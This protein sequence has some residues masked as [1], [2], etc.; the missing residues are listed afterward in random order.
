MAKLINGGDDCDDMNLNDMNHDYAMQ[1][2]RLEPTGAGG[3][4]ATGGPH[5]FKLFTI[6][7]VMNEPSPEWRVEGL[8]PVKSLTMIYAPQAQYKTFF[9][10]DLALC[11]AH[12][13]DFHG[14][15]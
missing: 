10:L 13:A 11:V 14:R 8:M 6:D 5:R 3:V 2:P 15:P 9:A 12:G 7:D 4:I 1:A